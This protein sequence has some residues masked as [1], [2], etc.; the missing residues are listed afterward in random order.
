M[1]IGDYISIVAKSKKA[2]I[3]YKIFGT[4][5]L[6]THLRLKPLI[7]YFKSY[8]R[9]DHLNEIKILEIG[10]GSGVNMYEIYKIAKKFNQKF[11]YFGIDISLDS[12]S[13]AEKVAQ[14]IVKENPKIANINLVCADAQEFLGHHLLNS[15]LKYDFILLIDVIEHIPYSMIFLKK[16]YELLDDTGKIIISVPTPLY[17][18]IF[19]RKFASQIG[20]LVD[21]YTLET[22]DNLFSNIKCHRILHVYNTG[23]ISNL[24]TFIYYRV[25]FNYKLLNFLKSILLYPFKYFDILNS[26]YLSCSL[27][28]VYEKKDERS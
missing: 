12:I 20:H 1:P 15:T 13:A 26:K 23:L 19:G 24:G 14:I 3:I 7:R 22:L 5:D 2:K 16:I 28:C 11:R 6:H 21:G 18:R 25:V 4:L 8:F 10:C 27:F 17:P 9:K